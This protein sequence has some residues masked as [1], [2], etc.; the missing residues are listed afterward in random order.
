MT[1][2]TKTAG[3]FVSGFVAALLL[4]LA[5]VGAGNL[6]S[7]P[8]AFDFFEV[9]KK[10]W[11]CSGQNLY[12][13]HYARGGNICQLFVE[14]EVEEKGNGLIFVAFQ[15]TEVSSSR[16]FEPITA[17]VNPDWFVTFHESE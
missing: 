16:G 3:G 10:Y 17:W 7:A 6:R 2:R 8:Q 4:M 11:A 1:M 15:P 13:G 12:T 9:G 14:F 5:V